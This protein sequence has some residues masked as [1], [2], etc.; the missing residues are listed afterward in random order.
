MATDYAFVLLNK[1]ADSSW[2][3]YVAEDYS[4]LEWNSDTP[5]PTQQELD[6]AYP[7]LRYDNDYAKVQETRR[8]AYQRDAD[9]LFFGYQRGDN[10]EQEWLDAVQA[11]KDTYPYP[12]APVA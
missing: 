3:I 10:T 4:T 9:P 6:S 7:K 11:V 2:A 5:K 1:Y 12:E 8:Q